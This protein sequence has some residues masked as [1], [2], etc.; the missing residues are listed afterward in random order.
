MEYSVSVVLVVLY[1][2]RDR[3]SSEREKGGVNT[4]SGALFIRATLETSEKKRNGSLEENIREG[5]V[6]ALW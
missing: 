4:Y 5:K 2:R 3:V 1:T 6:D